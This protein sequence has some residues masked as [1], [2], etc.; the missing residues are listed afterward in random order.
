MK[1]TYRDIIDGLEDDGHH[2]LAARAREAY[3]SKGHLDWEIG[4]P[5]RRN[6]GMMPIRP[7]SEL[8]LGDPVVLNAPE[9]ATIATVVATRSDG[10]VLWTDD[11]ERIVW[12]ED[13]IRLLRGWDAEVYQQESRRRRELVRHLE[14]IGPDRA[15][16]REVWTLLLW[17][18]EP[19][20]E[21]MAWVD[22]VQAAQLELTVRAQLMA[23]WVYIRERFESEAPAAA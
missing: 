3:E 5:A 6:G 13:S 10:L 7:S 14:A 22:G 20:A 16:A 8:Q 1:M 23:R 21:L 15:D 19:D 9:N 4:E 11:G 18:S 12:G 2:E 17:A